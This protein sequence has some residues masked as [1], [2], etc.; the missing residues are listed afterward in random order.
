M[1]VIYASGNM[2]KNRGVPS[3]TG[4]TDHCRDRT[5]LA[6]RNGR[7]CSDRV[8]STADNTAANDRCYRISET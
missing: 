8:I 4:T 6:G 2:C 5:S 7:H 3:A 1:L